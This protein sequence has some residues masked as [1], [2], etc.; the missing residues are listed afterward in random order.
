MGRSCR[1]WRHRIL[2]P[3]WL[4]GIPRARL[5]PGT[6]D[7]SFLFYLY[8]FFFC[9]YRRL[10]ERGKEREKKEIEIETETETERGAGRWIEIDIDRDTDKKKERKSNTYKVFRIHSKT[11]WTLIT[12][13]HISIKKRCRTL[14]ISKQ[15]LVR[16]PDNDDWQSTRTRQ[17]FVHV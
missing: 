17:I 1:L 8:I 13:N 3:V 10:R 9:L 11:N 6:W 12:S 5:V 15:W 16:D 7:A 2:C 14:D 4:R